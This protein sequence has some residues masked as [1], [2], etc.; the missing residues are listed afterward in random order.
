MKYKTT[1]YTIDETQ[2]PGLKDEKVGGFPYWPKEKKRL[3]EQY[4]LLAQVH[5]QKG[6]LQFFISQNNLKD[7]KVIFHETIE[8]SGQDGTFYHQCD[9]D[10]LLVSH[11]CRLIPNPKIHDQEASH[12][13]GQPFYF[14][15]SNPEV[16]RAHDILLFQ[17]NCLCLGPVCCGTPSSFLFYISS[18]DLKKQD[19]SHVLMIYQGIS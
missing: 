10:L 2:I 11:P 15:S 7:G 8:E 17:F 14:L 12:L 1:Y 19:F 5:Y 16:D 3:D 18:E 13:F 9:C 4:V 6:M